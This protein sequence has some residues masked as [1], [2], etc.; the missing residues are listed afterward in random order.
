[1]FREL[2]DYTKQSIEEMQKK[3]NYSE[4]RCQELDTI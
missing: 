4:R 3:L 1:M 2:S